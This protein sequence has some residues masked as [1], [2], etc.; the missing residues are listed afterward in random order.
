MM[1]LYKSWAEYAK[2]ARLR[3]YGRGRA[4]NILANLKRYLGIH[5]KVV[6]YYGHREKSATIARIPEKTGSLG[7]ILSK[8]ALQT[9]SDDE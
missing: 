3:K 2:E 6:I 4:K 5:E 7:I 9:F 8:S 1:D